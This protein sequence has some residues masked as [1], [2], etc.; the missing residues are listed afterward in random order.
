MTNP[1]VVNHFRAVWFIERQ[2]QER[3]L[4]RLLMSVV[5]PL[6]S[7]GS[8]TRYFSPRFI[9]V[10]VNQKITWYNTDND[11]HSL[12]FDRQIIPYNI[13][14]G[15][16]SPRGTLTKIFDSYVPRIDYSCAIH[17]LIV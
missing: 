16:V 11:S 1:Q 9:K 8:G 15:D 14:I 10:V 3:G 7:K 2:I 5:I 13:K 4:I 6:R 17:P 12:I